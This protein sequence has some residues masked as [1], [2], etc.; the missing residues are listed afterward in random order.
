ME[1]GRNHVYGAGLGRPP[2]RRAPERLAVPS[3]WVVLG[4]GALLA[5]VFALT[6]LLRYMAWF[7]ASLV[8]E[9]GHTVVAWFFGQPAYPA[10]RLDG[11]AAAMHSD[12][13]LLLVVA[14]G[15]GLAALTWGLRQRPVLRVVAGSVLVLYPLLAFSQA[16]EVLHLVGGHLSEMAFAGVFFYRAMS[17]GFSESQAERFAYATMAWVLLGRNVLLDGGLIVSES[18]RQAYAGNG[19]FGL[20]NDFIRAGRH[21]GCSLETVAF[22][23]LLLALAVLP[24]AWWAWRRLDRDEGIPEPRPARPWTT[25]A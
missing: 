6:P 9:L 10:I 15:L 1:L 20:T 21:L 18:A 5:P 8:H 11:H 14:V 25:R 17:G 24:V 3:A 13:K 2:P 12:Q 23:M 22:F 7:L 19:S 4:V 16:H